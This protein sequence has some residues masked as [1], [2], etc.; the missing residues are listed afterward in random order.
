MEKNQF[1]RAFLLILDG[2]G[3]G[4][5][6]DATQFG[7]S[8]AN[9]MGNLASAFLKTTGRHLSLPHLERIGLGSIVPLLG[10]PPVG[11]PPPI[12]PTPSTL[13]S[14]PSYSGKAGF[15]KAAER[16][17]G[18]DTSSGHWEMMGLTVDKP[19]ATFPEGFPERLVNQWLL[20]NKLPG[21][22]GNCTASGTT[23]I[24]ELGLEHIRTQKPI[25][26][27]S[28]DSVWQV[29]AHEEHFGLER[30]Y[31]I[32]KSARKLCDQ[33]PLGRV[34]ARP[35]IG[36]PDKGIPF[37]RTYNRKDYAFPPHRPTCLDELTDLGVPTLGIGK[38]SSIFAGHGIQENWDSKGNEDGI[39]LIKKAVQDRRLGLIFCNLI[40]FDM[41]YGHRRDVKGF[42]IALEVFDQALGEILTALT[43]K[44]LVLISADH[45]NDP[46]FRGSD[47][48]REYVPILAFA[49]KPSISSVPTVETVPLN[50]RSSFGDI[51]ATI[52]EALTGHSWSSPHLVG[53]SFLK[54]LQ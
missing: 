6:P 32:C 18:K 7:D 38:I 51:G 9:T 40:D 43:P 24:D 13:S 15:G 30:L 2:A 36:D 11:L 17:A 49:P 37:K 42:G 19:F 50:I 46:T 12:K 54:L 33:I 1:D 16:S 8:G 31:E 27:T 29:A 14:G 48:T 23:I 3:V 20:D 39:R 53:H 25:L 47:H 34:I 44:D 21:V 26:Y 5:L 52:F 41:L 10:P 22:L 4:E 35:F 28:A 45:G